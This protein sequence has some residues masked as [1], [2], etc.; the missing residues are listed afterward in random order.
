MLFANIDTKRIDA[1]MDM[2]VSFNISLEL[3]HSVLERDDDDLNESQELMRAT[4]KT[5][6]ANIVSPTES[7]EQEFYNMLSKRKQ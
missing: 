5:Y 1:K 4:S 2:G 7:M 3:D 6:G